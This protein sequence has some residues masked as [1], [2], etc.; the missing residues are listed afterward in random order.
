[1]ESAV[2]LNSW[3]LT[4]TQLKTVRKI[5]DYGARYDPESGLSL[6]DQLLAC[7]CLASAS[8]IEEQQIKKDEIQTSDSLLNGNGNGA[9]CYAINTLSSEN[10]L[11]AIRELKR[12]TYKTAPL[13]IARI[14]QNLYGIPDIPERWL[15]VG[16]LHTPRQIIWTLLE[17]HKKVSR[18]EIIL[19]TPGA[20]F[21]TLIGFRAKRAFFRKRGKK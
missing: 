1:M 6:E 8:L 11:E 10:Y 4:S 12:Q 18:G 15:I 13:E 14:L 2:N 7:E 20:Y 21:T 19:K 3:Q 5:E 16:Q 9:C 17:I